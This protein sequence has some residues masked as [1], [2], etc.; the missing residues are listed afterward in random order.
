ML[1]LVDDTIRAL[2]FSPVRSTLQPNFSTTLEGIVTH[3]TTFGSVD[4]SRPLPSLRFF[5]SIVK[6]FGKEMELSAKKKIIFLKTFPLPLPQTKTQSKMQTQT[7]GNCLFNLMASVSRWLES[8]L[9][10]DY[11]AQRLHHQLMSKRL[12]A[13]I[14]YIQTIMAGAFGRSNVEH[15]LSCKRMAENL[16]TIFFELPEAK[17]RSERLIEQ[18]DYQIKLIQITCN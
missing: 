2:F 18:I 4:I 16:P 17:P 1:L 10:I 13:Q 12:D 11:E 3:N 15:L 6:S 5:F 8:K 7:L 9:G 14:L